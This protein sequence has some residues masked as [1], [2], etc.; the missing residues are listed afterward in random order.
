MIT[1]YKDPGLLEV[2][3]ED[4]LDTMIDE[5]I[6]GFC[7]DIHR[8][9]KKGN[10]D[11]QVILS[12][13]VKTG[14]WEVSQLTGDEEPPMSIAGHVDVRSEEKRVQIVVAK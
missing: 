2:A 5:V 1:F 9:F 7:F 8:L 6:L 4:V 13:V 10:R 3:S 12:R 11:S 14:A